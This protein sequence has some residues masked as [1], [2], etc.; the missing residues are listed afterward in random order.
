[1]ADY[2]AHAIIGR[3]HTGKSTFTHRF[4]QNYDLKRDRVLIV[5]ETNPN[6]YRGITRIDNIQKLSAWKS[7]VVK[8]YDFDSP[9]DFEMLIEVYNLCAKGIFK[10]GLCIFEDC[11]NYIDANPHRVIKKFIV[12]HRMYKLDLVFTTHSLAFL[13]KFCR[14]MI[15]TITIFK[16]GDTFSKWQELAALGYPNGKNL[17]N[18]WVK[19]MNHPDEHFSITISTGI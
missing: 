3:K 9:N 6:A 5:T 10:N 15:S 8:Y 11:T 16:T 14:R 1:M 18:A 12:N 4:F 13:P 19:V 17:Y 2:E 7:G